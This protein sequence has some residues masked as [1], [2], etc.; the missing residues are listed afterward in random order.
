MSTN[1]P[2]FSPFQHKSLSLPN[3]IVRALSRTTG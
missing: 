1:N 3:R 2:L